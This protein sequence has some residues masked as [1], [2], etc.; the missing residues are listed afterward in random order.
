MPT[1][2]KELFPIFRSA[3][4]VKE[5]IDKFTTSLHAGKNTRFNKN[6]ILTKI[7]FYT[8]RLN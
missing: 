3:Y 5:L 6:G 4:Q 1:Q 2:I 7:R 8:N